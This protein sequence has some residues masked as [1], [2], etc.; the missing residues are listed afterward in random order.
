MIQPWMI[1]ATVTF[2]VSLGGFAIRSRQDLRWAKRLD[3]P[4]WLVFEP[5]I[6]LIWTIIFAC[7][8]WSATIVWQHDPNSL[9]TWVLMGFYLLLEI[10]TVAYIP[11]TLRLRSLAVGTALGGLGLMFGLVLAVIVWSVSHT[12]AF[13]LLPYLLWSPIGTYTTRE[14]IDLNPEAV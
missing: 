12:A 4:N 3:R 9:K 10:T 13:L 2:L 8:A 11:L 6:P 5:A 7:G 14:M 1:I